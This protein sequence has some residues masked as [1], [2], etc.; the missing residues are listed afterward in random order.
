M[1]SLPVLAAAQRRQLTV[2]MRQPFVVSAFLCAVS[3]VLTS[4]VHKLKDES[5]STR[6]AWRYRAYRGHP[7]NQ[8]VP[9]W[10]KRALNT[11][12]LVGLQLKRRN[13]YDNLPEGEVMASE[14]TLTARAK[15]HIQQ[16]D[17]R[18]VPD[19]GWAQVMRFG[20]DCN[21]AVEG[22]SAGFEGDCGENYTKIG[23]PELATCDPSQS[24]DIGYGCWFFFSEGRS[25]DPMGFGGQFKVVEGSGVAVNVCESLQ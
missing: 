12:K 3:A 7:L 5:H 8:R 1:V 18:L 22:L 16:E 23:R 4:P 25:L 6:H 20:S 11:T 19:Y 9:E 13:S 17:R 2:A 15:S 21:A 10:M 24:K 14:A